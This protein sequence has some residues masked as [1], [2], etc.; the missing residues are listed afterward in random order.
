[1]LG[2][3]IFGSKTGDVIKGHA[4]KNASTESN[5]HRCQRCQNGSRE[6]RCY[7]FHAF[8]DA[9][10]KETR[11]SSG[12]A[13]SVM[14]Q[15]TYSGIVNGSAMICGTCVRRKTLIRVFQIFAFLLLGLVG[16]YLLWSTRNAGRDSGDSLYWVKL[17][18]LV[19][20]TSFSGWTFIARVLLLAAI[21]SGEEIAAELHNPEMR[22][23]GYKEVCG[24][25]LHG[26]SAPKCDPPTCNNPR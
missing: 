25:H 2:C 26:S 1:M 11:L 7:G 8:R 17:I 21:K 9:K 14:Y 6:L 16:G 4:M 19:L 5:D 3:G 15:T 12:P 13:S 24:G 18:G 20:I 10:T 23:L 22:R